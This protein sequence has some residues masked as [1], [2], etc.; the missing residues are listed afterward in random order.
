MT[1]VTVSKN[2]EIECCRSTCK[3][4]VSKPIISA[5]IKKLGHHEISGQ[6]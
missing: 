2:E 4:K 6:R 3:R 1:Q 5:D